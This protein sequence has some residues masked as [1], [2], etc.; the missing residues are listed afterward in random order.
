MRESDFFV[1]DNPVQFRIEV[2]ETHVR[3]L[4][5]EKGLERNLKVQLIKVE[6]KFDSKVQSHLE[7]M[8]MKGS[9]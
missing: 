2:K 7:R 8:E 4:D 9:V 6:T 5:C 3:W 1:T